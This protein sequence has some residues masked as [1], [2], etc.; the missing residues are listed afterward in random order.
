MSHLWLTLANPAPPAH[1]ANTIRLHVQVAL[2]TLQVIKY[3]KKVLP[4]Q[5]SA[6]FRRTGPRV[7]NP[8][9]LQLL[10]RVPHGCVNSTTAC[11]GRQ[12][13]THR[14]TKDVKMS[15]QDGQIQ[16]CKLMHTGSK[17]GEK[18]KRNLPTTISVKGGSVFPRQ[19][20]SA[21]RSCHPCHKKRKHVERTSRRKNILSCRRHNASNQS[22]TNR[23]VSN[24]NKTISCA[25]RAYHDLGDLTPASLWPQATLH[26]CSAESVKPPS[27]RHQKLRCVSSH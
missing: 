24:D 8:K 12:T 21:Q 10:H 20:L 15:S 26:F 1:E 16:Q 18:R 5:P 22:L 2:N 17:I 3:H 9:Q 6:P 4:N 11:R 19:N 23:T 27:I 13:Q 7:T 25:P 14:H